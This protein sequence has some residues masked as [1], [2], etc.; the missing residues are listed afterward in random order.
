M[1]CEKQTPPIKRAEQFGQREASTPALPLTFGTGGLR[2]GPK[3]VDRRFSIRLASGMGLLALLDA[4]LPSDVRTRA[5]RDNEL[6]CCVR[7]GFVLQPFDIHPSVFG[8]E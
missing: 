2:I 5:D 8:V 3:V 6:N 4:Q 7:C 1:S